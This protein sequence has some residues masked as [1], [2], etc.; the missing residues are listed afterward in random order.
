MTQMRLGRLLCLLGLLGITYA[1]YGLIMGRPQSTVFLFGLLSILY[2]IGE[3]YRRES[4]VYLSE[5]IAQ[6]FGLR[7]PATQRVEPG[8]VQHSGRQGLLVRY[9]M[10]MGVMLVSLGAIIISP[11]LVAVGKELRTEERT[12]DWTD[13]MALSASLVTVVAVLFGEN[14]VYAMVNAPQGKDR[15]GF[16][17]PAAATAVWG[18]LALLPLAYVCLRGASADGEPAGPDIFPVYGVAALLATLCL[19]RG[20]RVMRLYVRAKCSRVVK[21]PD[22]VQPHTFSLLLRPFDEDA[23]LMRDQQMFTAKSLVKGWFSIG[24]PEE[25][26]ICSALDWAGP[27]I[28]VGVPGE[29]LAP[30][31]AARFYLPR[32]QWHATVT[33]MMLRARLVVLILGDSDGVAW[34]LAEAFRVVPPERLML[35]VP[36]RA[37]GYTTLLRNVRE[38]LRPHLRATEPVPDFPDYGGGFGLSSRAQGIIHFTSGWRPIYAPLRAGFAPTDRLVLSLSRA[39]VPVAAQL[40]RYESGMPRDDAGKQD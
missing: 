27:M 2:I 22:E 9:G 28:A 39:S 10:Q 29:Q 40:R 38:A 19:A 1:A 12:A 23:P 5:S 21:S 34:E 18:M 3:R 13:L 35:V 31:G 37:A 6:E 36:V 26:K 15:P 20:N 4:L 25:Q 14:R 16:F 17:R 24:V 33:K 11:T 30:D 32:H 8:S 7:G